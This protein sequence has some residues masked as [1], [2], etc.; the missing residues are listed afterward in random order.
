MAKRLDKLVEVWRTKANELLKAIK[1]VQYPDQATRV[2]WY[3]EAM[4]LRRCANKLQYHLK[5]AKE[6]NERL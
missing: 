6:R 4:T 2:R 1:N 3:D 5:R